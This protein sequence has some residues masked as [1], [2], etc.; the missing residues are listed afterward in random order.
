MKLA[1]QAVGLSFPSAYMHRAR[2]SGF[3]ARWDA[4][5]EEGYYAL[6]TAMLADAI[7]SLDT[8]DPRTNDCDYEIISEPMT[9]EHGLA[10]LRMN[11][12]K[13]FRHWAR[14]KGVRGWGGN[15]REE[16]SGTELKESI[17][18]KLAVLKMRMDA[19]EV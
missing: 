15:R 8:V 11:S 16:M 13:A 17:L 19:G 2:W 4:A 10:V 14:A 3:A 12:G 1:C 6:E 5:V 9:P 7:R 18:K